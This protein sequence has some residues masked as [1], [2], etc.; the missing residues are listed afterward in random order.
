MSPEGRDIRPTSDRTKE[1]LFNIIQWD[2][3]GSTFID[4]FSG[5]GGI[6]IEAISRGADKVYFSDLDRYAIDLISKNLFGIKG[7]YKLTQ[8]DYKDVLNRYKH[9]GVKADF[10]YVDPPYAYVKDNFKDILDTIY[11]SGVLKDDGIVIV[12]HGTDIRTKMTTS[13]FALFDSR[14]YGIAALDFYRKHVKGLVSGTFDPFTLGH[15]FVVEEALK[16]V[17]ILYIVIFENPEKVPALTIDERIEIIKLAT[18]DLDEDNV[19]NVS[20][21]RGYVKDYCRENGISV[22]YRGSRNAKD[23]AFEKEMAAYN[24]EHCGVETVIVDAK[25]K[26]ISSTIVKDRLKNDETVEKYI[27]TKIIDFLK[28]KKW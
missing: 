3:E 7:D 19:I 15:L 16:E 28:E 6:G 27:D 21:Y 20:S 9:N 4:L 1:A 14:R 26:F 18:E 8:G 11:N 25:D 17:D 24:L 5:T 12:E 22:I 10:I 13:K 2:I 23:Y